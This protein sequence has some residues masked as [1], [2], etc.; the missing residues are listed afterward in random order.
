MNGG[1]IP[2]E[3]VGPVKPDA[4]IPKPSLER[5]E[6]KPPTIETSENKKPEP[7]ML[8]LKDQYV[9]ESKIAD[10]REELK[11]EK[12]PYS[13]SVFLK[14][15]K[16][17]QQQGLPLKIAFLDID[18]TLTGNP[19]DA[20]RV[21]ELLD[22]QG[23]ATVFV[24]SRTGEMV[25]S[26]DS[27]EKSKAAGFKRPAPKLGQQDGLRVGAFADEV[28][29]F[30]GLYDPDA[31]AATTG[32]EIMIRQED[33]SCIE[34][35]D[36]RTQMREEHEAWRQ[37]TLDIARLVDP[38][39]ELGTWASIENS[40]NF[41]EGKVDVFSPDT[42]IQIDFKA[43]DKKVDSTGATDSGNSE[44]VDTKVYFQRMQELKSRIFSLSKDPNIPS[45]LKK[46]LLNIRL[47]DDSNPDKGRYSL[48][49]TPHRGYKARAVEQTINQA[50]QLLGAKNSDFE[51]LFAGD[52]WPDVAMGLYGGVGKKGALF[53]AS[54]SRL[55][56][57]FTEENLTDFA[58]QGVG[59]MKGRMKSSE[60]GNIEANM[61]LGTRRTVILGDELFPG[62]SPVSSVRAYLESTTK[63]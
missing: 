4:E 55:S 27:F 10:V 14:K 41:E 22:Q 29:D 54:G 34:D 15:L 18:S 45:D 37:K 62:M 5:P 2:V 6:Q 12:D 35:F 46:H 13:D 57:T 43:P 33:G 36:F 31:I 59:A 32:S 58:G 51:L 25:M 53:L 11:K 30:K 7:E 60:D 44:T 17:R 48:Y 23:Y 28:V 47:T 40:Q 9:S 56:K 16:E 50:Q 24:T 26:R 42:R 49:L 3:N 1:D 8:G 19:G 52:S 20:Q 63:N 39:Q 21:R 38:N 61:P